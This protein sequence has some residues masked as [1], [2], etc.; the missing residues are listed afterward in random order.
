[1]MRDASF[2]NIV[3]DASGTLDPT[4]ESEVA[5]L[6]ATLRKTWTGWAVLRALYDRL[7]PRSEEA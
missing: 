1:M 3:I 2:E 4:Y 6:L 7:H 5:A